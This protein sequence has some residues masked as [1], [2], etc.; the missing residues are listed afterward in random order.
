MQ[1]IVKKLENCR[2]EVTLTF[3]PEEWKA[4]RDAALNKLA[5]NVEI[6]GFRKGHAP[7]QLAKERIR[8]SDIV[9]NA[10]DTVL[11]YS[12]TKVLTEENIIPVARPTVN[13]NKLSDTEC[14]VVILIPT[15]P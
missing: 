3:E 2:T 12:Y 7:I 15:R 14:E 5:K 13:V 11:Q 10:L 8:E 9:N 6:K 4:A 1:K